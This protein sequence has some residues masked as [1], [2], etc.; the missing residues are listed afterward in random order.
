MP[1]VDGAEHECQAAWAVAAES[2]LDIH[3]AASR[4][5]SLT[6][7]RS[8]RRLCVG[9]V[10]LLVHCVAPHTAISTMAKTM[11]FWPHRVFVADI[12]SLASYRGKSYGG[13]KIIRFPR[14]H[15]SDSFW[16]WFRRPILT[17]CP[18]LS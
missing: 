9:L 5:S 11:V 4:A 7:L 8:R 10:R 15:E 1:P 18:T 17:A 16:E 13:G 12:G 6:H 14:R 2:F 3:S